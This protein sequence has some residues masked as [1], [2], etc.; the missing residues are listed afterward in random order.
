MSLEV[1]L[2][3]TQNELENKIKFIRKQMIVIQ[4]FNERFG[5]LGQTEK[6]HTHLEPCE[7]L[8]TLQQ[9][10][11]RIKIGT[12]HERGTKQMTE[13]RP[14]LLNMDGNDVTRAVMYWIPEFRKQKV[15]ETAQP[16]LTP[17]QKGSGDERRTF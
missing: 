2:E 15:R 9:K 16:A 1:Q 10:I 5:Q 13:Q 3:E 7:V 6:H 14:D 8:E 11:W 12:L 4:A 17:W